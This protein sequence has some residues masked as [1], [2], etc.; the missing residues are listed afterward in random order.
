MVIL[1]NV[2][3]SF[4]KNKLH[5]INN[6]SLEFENNGLVAIL[7]P[8][9]CGKTTLL[10]C[11]GGLDKIKKGKILINNQ[12]ISSKI[13]QKVDKIRNLNIG[14]IFQDYKLIENMSVYDNVAIV[15]KMI[16]IKD[17]KEIKKRVEYVLDKVGMLRYKRRPANMLSGGERQRVGIARAIVKNPSII[18]ADE[19]TGNLDS[20][21]SLEVMK[22]IKAIS[23]DRLV[24]LVTHEQNLAK[25]YASRIIE[26][27]DGNIVKDYKNDNVNELDYEIDNNFYLKD[28]KYKNNINKEN[29]DIE[30]FSNNEDKIKL[31]I[32]IKNGNIYIKSNTKE[33]VEV[34]DDNSSIEFIDDHFKKIDKSEIEKLEFDFK[35]IINKNIKKKYSSILNPFTLIVQGFK[36]VFDFPMLKK[37]LLIGFFISGMFIMY[38]FASILST[39]NIKDEDFVSINKNYLVVDQNKLSVKD[40]LDY[41][42]V[43]DVN[44]I[45]PGN[46]NITFQFKNTDYYQTSNTSFSL[47]GSLSDISMINSEDLIL[48]RMP[49]KTQEIIVDKFTIQKALDT[50]AE[51]Q[52]SGIIDFKDMLNKNLKLNNMDDFKIVGI[53]DL[54]S[55]SIYA[56]KNLFVNMLYNTNDDKAQ[57]QTIFDYLLFKDKITLKEGKVPEND[58]EIIVNINNKESMPL[59]KEIN[60]KINDTK[61]K[62]VGYYD[63]EYN[64]DYYFTNN[65]TI[66]Y[67]LIENSKDLAILSSNDEEVISSFRNLNLNINKSYD[68]SKAKYKDQVKENNRSTI[69]VSLIMLSISLIEMLLMIRS[70]F[71]SRIKEIGILRAIGVKKIDIYK[72]FYGEIFAITTLA[73]LPGLIFMAYILKTITKVK[74]LSSL[75]LINPFTIL[76]S[77]IL[78]YLFNL[79][80]G[81]IPVFNVVRKTPASI[82]S[83]HDLD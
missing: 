15:L 10:N 39:F 54:K 5:V 23:K 41:E 82:L 78:V 17:K 58:Y 81:L 63:S 22:I 51:F 4:N 29:L 35:N 72:M 68:Y 24:I 1:E 65:N 11:I 2:D 38:S 75:F 56:N 34:V 79:V 53:T 67:T 74:M 14:Y 52:M 42:K 21:N 7:G 40:Y 66:K 6:I 46:S 50:V 60:L 76:L 71:L 48:G 69:L 45:I 43:S 64:Y 62:V 61:L 37:I 16:G 3:K 31:D 44:Y 20:K 49:E 13:P 18:L 80:I 57:E 36:K 26:V 47:S 73:S 27:K 83:R 25:F 55:P 28:F 70:S 59:Q 33:K 77:V 30:I 12:K 19:P 9:G 32:V 8:S